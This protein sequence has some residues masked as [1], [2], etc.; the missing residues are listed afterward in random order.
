MAHIVVFA[1]E[2]D[3]NTKDQLRKELSRFHSV[4]ELVLDLSGIKYIDS[5]FI[6]ELLVLVRSRRAE[7]FPR[8]T[9]VTPATSMVRRLFEVTGILP[10]F[11][12]VESYS[13]DAG[14][15]TCVTHADF[16]LVTA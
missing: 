15:S 9:V 5:T 1:G 4:S 14:G 16:S 6:S 2:Y 11:H 13:N 8:I 3:L 12:V 10:L 7:G